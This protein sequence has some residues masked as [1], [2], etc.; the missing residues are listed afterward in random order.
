MYKFLPYNNCRKIN[1]RRTKENKQILQRSGAHT[2][3]NKWL[4]CERFVCRSQIN[5]RGG[6]KKARCN[7]K[8][9]HNQ[10]EA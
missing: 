10:C 4:N 1:A 3:Y 6:T 8:V 9:M 7:E 5:K 2:M